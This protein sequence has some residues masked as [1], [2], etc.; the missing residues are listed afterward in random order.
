MRY[1]IRG[2][3]H[4]DQ[5]HIAS[6]LRGF[7]AHTGPIRLGYLQIHGVA[8]QTIEVSDHG[9]PFFEETVA[10]KIGATGAFVEQRTALRRPPALTLTATLCPTTATALPNLTAW[11]GVWAV[12]VY[13]PRRTI[14]RL[15]CVPDDAERLRALAGQGWRVLRGPA[16]LGAWLMPPAPFA[17]QFWPAPAPPPAAAAAAP[18]PTP[19]AA[20]AA[21]APPAAAP[22]PA[23]PPG[24][25]ATPL[26]MADV[27]AAPDA[28]HLLV[29]VTLRGQG[30]RLAW[31]AMTIAVPEGAPDQV[32]PAM[33]VRAF[34]HG[35]GALVLA[36]RATLP[37]RALA[38]LGQRLRVIDMADPWESPRIPWRSLPPAELQRLLGSDLPAPLPATL[39]DV[40]RAV[41]QPTLATPVVEALTRE[42][43]HDLAGTL[44]AGGGVVLLME[45]GPAAAFLG[46]VLLLHLSLA[47]VTRPL[48]LCRPATVPLP[49]ALAARAIQIVFG[50]DPTAAMELRAA[51]Q[52]WRA[53]FPDGQTLMLHQNLAAAVEERAGADHAALISALQG[54]GWTPD[55]AG[56]EAGLGWPADGEQPDAAGAEAGLGWPADGEQPDAAG[57]EAGLAE[58]VIAWRAGTSLT[59]LARELRSQQPTLSLLDAM[60]VLQGA[61]HRARARAQPAAPGADGRW[62]PPAAPGA[63]GRWEPPAAPGADAGLVQVLQHLAAGEPDDPVAQHVLRQWRAGGQRRH[64]VRDLV[65]AHGMRP[66]DARAFYDRVI[67][68]YVIAELD[69]QA[70]AVVRFLGQ[71][72]PQG[73]IPPGVSTCIA[74]LVGGSTR[75]HP[76]MIRPLLPGLREVLTCLAHGGRA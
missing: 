76:G 16:A 40:L 68:P 47:R 9:A 23:A 5:T 13:G 10:P 41:G 63:D 55:A 50:D 72:A 60:R 29:G 52:A 7:I 14:V 6:E 65:V 45:P 17:P 53:R 38:A 64:I 58:L 70:D 31:R 3:L 26:T 42:P 34:T 39:A 21:P 25:A 59:V 62:E 11:A 46:S 24:M 36:E 1:R 69:G 57:A 4:A 71:P 43:A 18:A 61:I 54:G 12:V 28:P 56:A 19:P 51:A 37:P 30:V 33:L 74:R 44:E 15:R 32:I 20:A 8:A 35:M 48:L 49:A 75:A 66:A 67:L 27:L 2:P 22:A 73:A